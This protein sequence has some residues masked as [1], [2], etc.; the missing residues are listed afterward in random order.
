MNKKKVAFIA[1]VNDAVEWQEC[2]HY[3]KHLTVP[4]GMETEVLEIWDAKSMTGGYQEGM[5]S[6]NA[7]YKVYLHQDC[8]IINTNFIL[9]ML[10]I[11]EK[12]PQIGMMGC[13]GS[14]AAGDTK[15]F[16]NE[17]DAGKVFHNLNPLYLNYSVPL[18]EYAKVMAIDG[19]LM[20]TQC[21]VDWREDLFTGWH[22][23][24]LSQSMEMQRIEKEV[25]VPFQ[26][27]PWCYHDC[28]RG[29]LQPYYDNFDVFLKEYGEEIGGAALFKD[30]NV[31]EGEEKRKHL[32]QC[33]D[34]I[35]EA[36]EKEAFIHIFQH[37][38]MRAYLPFREYRI[39]AD[40]EEK[41]SKECVAKPFWDVNLSKDG[42]MEKLRILRHMIKRIEYGMEDGIEY[43]YLKEHYSDVAV[44]IMIQE[45]VWNKK[46]LGGL[47]S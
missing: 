6:T 24:D 18:K 36:G 47:T 29:L 32:E 12:N 28:R 45:Y 9:D 23:Y 22:F 25:V 16:L 15:G 11:F 34:V 4:L 40:I 46:K 19:L 17:W 43:A 5:V 38:P 1:C 31:S 14:Q 30:E 20:A 44:D 27:T 39:I 37:A 8:F 35:L 10:A 26:Q 21:D 13:V 41:E 3:L 33:M 42:V 2:Q 7:K